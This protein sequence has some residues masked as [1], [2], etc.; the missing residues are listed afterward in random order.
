MKMNKEIQVTLKTSSLRYQLMSYYKDKKLY[1]E[2]M[3]NMEGVA[4]IF[5][6]GAV[7]IRYPELV[8][9]GLSMLVTF[10]G[11]HLAD[12]MGLDMEKYE[13]GRKLKTQKDVEAEA[14]RNRSMAIIKKEFY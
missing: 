1:N 4:L 12:K 10:I 13:L 2:F 9:F 7:F 6:L 8:V 3:Y 11:F 14:A 5:T